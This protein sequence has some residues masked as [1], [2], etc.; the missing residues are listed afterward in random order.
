[1][2]VPIYNDEK[3]IKSV[4]RS[5]QNQNMT[6]IEIILVNDFSKDNTLKIIEEMKIEDP[7]I[8]IINNEKNKGILY[9]RSIA[10]LEAKGKYI[11]NLDQDDFILDEDVFEKV[12]KEAE[13]GNFDIISFM[14]IYINNYNAKINEM[15]DGPFTHHPNNY[16]V[17]QPELTYFAF[18]KDEHF[19]SNDI[20]IWGKLFRTEVYK[21]AVNLL[22]KERFSTYNI[23]NED[24]VG[25]F[26]I[27]NVAQ[28]YK[29]FRKYGLFHLINNPTTSSTKVSREHRLEMTIFFTNVIFDL[30]KNENKKYAAIRVIDLFDVINSLST[31]NNSSVEKILKKII[32]S[33]YID[34]KYK[35]IIRKKY[36]RF[37]F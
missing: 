15:S 16:I 1:M 5:I 31:K 8:K 33:E 7:R 29:Y 21:N 24:L 11:I 28:S 30:S 2:I 6:D 19:I 37:N 20:Q 17:R 25:L 9:S 18:Y 27:C 23:I 34:D 4:I 12:Y 36:N 35:Q 10:V 14:E 3:I 13:N 26:A 22:G 32:I